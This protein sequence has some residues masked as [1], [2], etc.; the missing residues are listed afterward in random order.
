MEDSLRNQYAH[1]PERIS[2]LVDLAY[3]LWWSWNPE[4]RALFKQVNPQAWK[5]SIHNPVRMLREIPIEFLKRAAENPAYLRRYDIVMRRFRKYLNAT[6][7]WF[8]EQYPGH[9]SLSVAYFSAEYGLHHSLP[10]YAGGLGFLAGDHLKEASD[11]GLPMVAIGFMY[12]QGYLHQQI[13]PDGW[14]ED[15]TEPLDHDMAPLTRVL[16]SAGEDLVVQVPHID[17]PIYVAVWKVEVG[18]IPLYLL[19]TDIPCNEP[20]NR[21]ISSRLYTGDLEQR[22][23]QEIVLGIGGRK[24][25]HALGIEYAAV[26]LNEGHPA[27]ALL[28]RVRERVER[29]MEFD[30]AL[31]QVR[32]TSVF[33]SH[34]PVPAGHD[35][36]PIDLIDRYFK[37]YYPALGIDRKEFLQLGVH[38]QLP[39]SGFNMT[40]FALR[41]SEHHN[42]VSRTHGSVTRQMWRCLW[43]GTPE[44]TVPIDHV[45]N[46]VHVPTWLNHRMRD[47][48]DRH[49]GSTCPNWLTEHDEPA[50]WELIDEI[51]DAELWY[52]HTWLKAKLFNRIREQERARWAVRRGGGTPHPA[53]GGAFLNPSALTIGFARRFSTYK[54]A[55]L[56]FEDLERLKRIL[57]NR[58][59]PVQI[60][61][62]GKAHPADNEGKRVLQQIYR[63]TQQPEFG[64]R[65]AFVEDYNEKV[66][67]YLVH[68]V[69][70]WLNNPLPPME[71]SGTSGMKASLNGVLNLS[72]LDGWWIEGYNGRNGW[73]FGSEAP[74]YPGRDAADAAAIYDL[75]EKEVV[76]LYYNR[77]IDDVPHGWVKMM[78]ES[79]KSNGPRFSAR[80]MVKEYVTRYYPSLLKAADAGYV[81]IPGEAEPR[82]PAWEP[83]AQGKAREESD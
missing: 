57:N 45:T 34:T 73:A 28:E 8:S 30:E 65:I 19:D 3:N 47:L 63:Y 6:G 40:A 11:L 32:A 66:A 59:Y 52:L 37:A 16:D 22:L 75:L 43:P 79:I 78:K 39:N 5:E 9:R 81:R 61:F 74:A 31:E 51:P 18:R 64:G 27:F 49:I 55:Y 44:A 14:Q 33:T 23:R 20:G 41:A 42:G 46:G 12:S 2:G 13:N 67:Q 10:I 17:P 36:F 29:G 80:R 38:P 15:I 56:I 54:R 24:V 83:R 82:A 69:D 72:I 21:G 70:V 58:W 53:V 77:S 71:A 25:L 48:Y 7:T 35:V 60:I 1:V 68:G 76:P 4:V 50:V 26:H 62:A